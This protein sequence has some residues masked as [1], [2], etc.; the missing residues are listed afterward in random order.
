MNAGASTVRVGLIQTHAGV[1]PDENLERALTLVDRAAD[2]GAQVVCL[3]ELFRSRYF[4]QEEDAA[5]FALAET[6][7]GPSTRALGERA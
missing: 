2:E 1:D 7:P 6:I 5:H 3:P 4:C